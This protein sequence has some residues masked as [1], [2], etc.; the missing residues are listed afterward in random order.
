LLDGS[1]GGLGEELSFGPGDAQLV[2]E[3]MLHLFEIDAVEVAS[4]DDA[5]G[6]GQRVAVLEEIE[7]IILAGRNEGQMRFGVGLELA[8]G[9]EFGE[10]MESKEACLRIPTQNGTGSA[11][12]ATLVP[13]QIGTCSDANRHPRLG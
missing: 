4:G 1:H 11:G 7:K 13:I 9:M 12:K 10:D 8:E 3:V 2:G 5:R 6:Q